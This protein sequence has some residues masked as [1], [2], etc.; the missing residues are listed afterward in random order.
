MSFEPRWP[1]PVV[2]PLTLTRVP[3][4]PD[5]CLFSQL[6][7]GQRPVSYS[8][9]L[10]L[11]ACRAEDQHTPRAMNILVRGFQIGANKGKGFLVL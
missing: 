4:H 8:Q 9:I 1:M 5:L 6:I 11:S 7:T 10:L 3:F 2:P